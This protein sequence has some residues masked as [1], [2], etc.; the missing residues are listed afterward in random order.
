MEFMAIV[1]AKARTPAGCAV[2]GVYENGELGL[3]ARQVDKQ[4]AGM[5]TNLLG[6]GDF[7]AKL[8]ASL[9][10]PSPDGSAV[11]RPLLVVLVTPA[12]FGRKQSRRALQ[13]IAQALA[14]AGAADAV[15]FLAMDPVPE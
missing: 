6:S 5:I 15:V 4:L 10:L 13:S 7:A 12:G 14:R 1:D 3:A 2:V 8:G 9:M 11:P